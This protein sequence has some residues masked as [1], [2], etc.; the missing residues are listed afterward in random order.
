VETLRLSGL[1]VG[2]VHDSRDNF[3]N[4]RRGI[5][6]NAD[7]AAY[8][9]AIGSQAAF[10]KFFSQGSLFRKVPGTASGPSRSGWGWRIR[11]ACPIPCLS[12]SGSTP[13]G[14]RR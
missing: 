3:Y 5:F 1:S 14:T 7:L 8:G 9:E 4:P 13:E 10:L 2:E 12:R 6:A 11:S